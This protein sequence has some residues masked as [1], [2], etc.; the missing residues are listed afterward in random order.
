MVEGLKRRHP[1]LVEG[2]RHL[3]GDKGYDASDNNKILLEEYE[4]KPVIDTRAMW[5]GE[6]GEK[7]LYY[8]DGRIDNILFDERGGLHCVFPSRHD[9]SVLET[10]SMA[11][12]GY[13]KDRGTLKY[14]CPAVAYGIS[15]P[16]K[17]TGQCGGKGVGAYGRIVRAPL[18]K[19]RRMFVPVV[20][21]SPKWKR[22]YNKRTSVERVNS[23]L[24]CSFGFERHYIRGLKKMRLQVSL[25]LIVMLSMALSTIKEGRQKNMRSLVAPFRLE[26]AA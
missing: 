24:D 16:L 21:D 23:R 19:D 11:F 6:K 18:D 10:A 4:I 2:A 25:A 9:P 12:C 22:L 26:K 1:E 7:R 13:E 17:G 5:K 15:C 3:M 8:E 14:R 20:R